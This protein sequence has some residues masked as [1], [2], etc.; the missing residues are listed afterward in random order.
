MAR[1]LR[2]GPSG[3]GKIDRMNELRGTR[4]CGFLWR[5]ASFEALLT[6]AKS[7]S[8]TVWWEKQCEEEL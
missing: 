8:L 6:S 3:I 2:F 5:S 1:H 7:L 4:M